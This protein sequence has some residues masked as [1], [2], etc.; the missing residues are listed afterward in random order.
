M[1]RD[2]ISIHFVNA[3]L[4][5]V[6]RLGLDIDTLLSHVGIEAEL[7]KQPKARISPDQYTQFA[8]MLWLVTQDEHIGFDVQPRKLGTFAMMLSLIHI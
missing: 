1:S 7:L 5:G 3:A 8:R 2:T 6:K 4:T